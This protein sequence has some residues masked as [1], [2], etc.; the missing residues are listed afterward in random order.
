MIKNISTRIKSKY[1]YW[2][3]IIERRKVLS[4]FCDG[5]QVKLYNWSKPFP[6]DLWL[7]DFIEKRGIL[8]STPRA[9][10]A[11]YSIFGATKLIGI[12]R[13]NVRIFVERE[14]LH[15]PTMRGWPHRYLDDDRFDLSLGFDYLDH[16]QYMRFPFW[17]MWTA[18]S[19]T[20]DYAEIKREIERM[21]SRD[22]HSYDDRKFC[23]YVCSHDDI[24]RRQTY[25]QFDAIDHIDCDGKLFH[26]NDELKTIFNDDKIAYLRQYRFNLTPENTNQKDYVTEKLFE[27]VSAGCIPIYHGSD[28][29]PEPE[30]LNPQAI[31]FMEVGAE[32]KDAIKLVSELN[33][34]RKKY[35][36]YACQ[37]RF[38]PEAADIIWEY[39]TKLESRIIEIL[40]NI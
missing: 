4:N 2:E 24:G 1:K 37:P 17:L 19:P 31:V 12:D 9:K 10:I 22:N 15:K 3:G 25:K 30:I 16:P 13:A 40:R 35:L 39:Y 29:A 7:I 26:N 23:S 20:A 5:H 27:A 11:L 33:S 28:N 18:F 8:K 14:N 21:N 6:Q 32:N 36:D 34:D 38:K